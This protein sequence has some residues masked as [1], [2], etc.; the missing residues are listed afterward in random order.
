MMAAV[1]L[2]L[3]AVTIVAFACSYWFTLDLAY[4]RIAIEPGPAIRGQLRD[5]NLCIKR[6]RVDL[7]RDVRR[8]HDDQETR[9]TYTE[10]VDAAGL[11][12]LRTFEGLRYG[13]HD[14]KGHHGSGT[15]NIANQWSHHFVV[16]PMAPLIAAFG[17]VPA[18]WL[19]SRVRE[20]RRER[21]GT[22]P[23]C[24]YDLRATPDRCPECGT[25]PHN[26]PMHR[27]GPAV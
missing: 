21:K 1:S 26:P 13:T 10:F 27:T 9:T 22:C 18:A 4:R 3:L 24:G 11:A 20:R 5:Y 12:R 14:L 16:I 25:T 2:V 6:G 17:L 7:H 19:L 8:V 23:A 15:I